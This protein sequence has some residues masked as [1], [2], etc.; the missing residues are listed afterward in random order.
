MAG[1]RFDSL[2]P[3]ER[4]ICLKDRQTGS[5]DQRG[6]VALNNNDEL[7]LCTVHEA[8][9]LF[10]QIILRSSPVFPS[11]FLLS[12]SGLIRKTPGQCLGLFHGGACVVPL[13]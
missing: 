11:F 9:V 1:D 3:V 10:K 6:A 5:K 13:L 12:G 4:D 2:P 7:S 8:S